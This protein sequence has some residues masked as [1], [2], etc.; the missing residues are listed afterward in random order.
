[1][2]FA[3]PA[4]SG[5]GPSP[6]AKGVGFQPQ[7]AVT[8]WGCGAD[9]QW[10]SAAVVAAE[11]RRRSSPGT[12]RCRCRIAPVAGRHRLEPHA[13]KRPAP[14]SLLSSRAIPRNG[15]RL[16][17]GSGP[18]PSPLAKGVGFQPQQAVTGWGCG[19]DIQWTSAAAVAAELRRRNST[20]IRRCQKTPRVERGSPLLANVDRSW[21]QFSLRPG[22]QSDRRWQNSLR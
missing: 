16:T 4:G 3:F 12:S 13:L 15:F 7:Q 20:D 21:R 5:P 6:L 1:M 19:A 17:A 10:M 18:G 14:G 11:L 9:I 2:A 22:W 8:G